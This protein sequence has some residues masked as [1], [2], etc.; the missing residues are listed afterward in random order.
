MVDDW[1]LDPSYEQWKKDAFFLYFYCDYSASDI[2]MVNS[3]GI[4]MGPSLVYLPE[5]E[6]DIS[7]VSQLTLE[8]PARFVCLDCVKKE[9]PCKECK[10]RMRI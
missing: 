9:E 8:A 7:L 1:E 5:E 3:D 4:L 2:P 10:W 6:D